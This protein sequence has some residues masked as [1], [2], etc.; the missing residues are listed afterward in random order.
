MATNMFEF[1]SRIGI[2][3]KEVKV[4]LYLLSTDS[5]PPMEIAK[6][7]HIKRSTVYV[8]LDELK[9]SGLVREVEKGHRNSYVAEDP[10]RIR[11]LL[12]DYKVQ[13]EKSIKTLDA[14]LPSMKATMRRSGEPPLIKY[15]EGEDAVKNSMD[16]L[17]GNPHFR[18]E[19]DY[20]VFPLELVYDLFRSRN[21]K[22]FHN[23]RFRSNVK[24][25][26]LYT[27]DDGELSVDQSKEQEAIKVD[28]KEHPLSCDISIFRD[29]VR[30]HMLGKNIY[31]IMIKNAELAETLKSLFKMAEKGARSKK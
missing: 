23:L 27:A 7:T 12:E 9:K 30:F 14:I 5:A 24:F 13:T 3:E 15:Y 25:K 11:Y 4:Y 22:K 20:G 2:S 28:P 26:A 18:E 6:E 21:L 8:I 17:V 1:L 19:M 31:G 16:E 10:D 29:E